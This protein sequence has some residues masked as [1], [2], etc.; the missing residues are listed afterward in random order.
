MELLLA[1]MLGAFA[2]AYIVGSLLLLWFI[3]ED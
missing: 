1:C 2:V 3:W